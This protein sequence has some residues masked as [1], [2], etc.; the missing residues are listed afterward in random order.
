MAL[1]LLNID[2]FL[3]PSLNR[4][5]FS[6]KEVHN[7]LCI[8]DPQNDPAN[9][10]CLIDAGTEVTFELFSGAR[11]FPFLLG[12]YFVLF[13]YCGRSQFQ[14]WMDLISLFCFLFLPQLAEL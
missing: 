5:E 4:K 13:C 6:V 7:E 14:F 10:Y 1:S 9:D 11:E 8:S 3:L 2:F 12:F